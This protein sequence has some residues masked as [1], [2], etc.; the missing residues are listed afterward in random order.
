M[1]STIAVLC[2]PRERTRPH[3]HSVSS[4]I[5]TS[6]GEFKSAHVT[7]S[8]RCP[9]SDTA[10]GT[11]CSVAACSARRAMSGL[12]RLLQRQERRPIWPCT[13][14]GVAE[15]IRWLITRAVTRERATEWCRQEASAL[16]TRASASA[17]L[18]EARAGRPPRFTA[19]RRAS[20]CMEDVAITRQVEVW[21]VRA[22]PHSQEIRF[23]AVL[24]M[25]R[26]RR[27]TVQERHGSAAGAAVRARLPACT[28]RRLG[29]AW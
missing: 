6:F 18:M 27:S 1:S 12:A 28:R 8:L 23:V 29:R 9:G 26:R 4:M 3:T 13:F 14:A 15:V 20:C 7:A 11:P 2:L 16:S 24:A 21:G 10:A 22:R 5:E 19:A 25:Q 17:L